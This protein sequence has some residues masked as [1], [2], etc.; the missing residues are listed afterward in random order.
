MLSAAYNHTESYPTMNALLNV[1]YPYGPLEVC[2]HVLCCTCAGRTQPFSL[3]HPC[4]ASALLQPV[5][6]GRAGQD[7]TGRAGQDETG[8]A[9]Q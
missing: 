7:E 5:E 6:T 8:R 2:E 1:R 4:H 9:G 3:P